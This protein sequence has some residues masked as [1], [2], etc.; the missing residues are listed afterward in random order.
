M[1]RRG[2]EHLV[3]LFLAFGLVETKGEDSNQV[4]YFRFK[5]LLKALFVISEKLEF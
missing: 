1:S 4:R 3:S 5:D 2:F